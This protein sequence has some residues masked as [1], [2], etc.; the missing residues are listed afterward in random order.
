MTEIRTR[1]DQWKAANEAL[2]G[3]IATVNANDPIIIA[4]RVRLLNE[5]KDFLDQQHYAE[6]FDSRSNLHSS[7]LEEFMYFLFKDLVKGISE[8]ALIGKSHSF[9]D[10]F[11]R[12][13][14]YQE[15][16]KKPYALVEMRISRNVTAD[17]ASS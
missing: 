12:A 8:N 10:V 3:P 5:Y 15:M 17:F 7:V 9:K 4:E 11:F 13:P 16:V 6:Q 2:I 14:S 1:Y